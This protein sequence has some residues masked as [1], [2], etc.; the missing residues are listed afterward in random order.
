MYCSRISMRVISPGTSLSGTGARL[1]TMQPARETPS[2][3]STSGDG[4]SLAG[5]IVSNRA[6]VPLK[7]VPGDITLMLILEQYIPFRQGTPQ[8]APYALTAILDNDLARRA[9]E[10]VGAG[11]DWVGQDVEHSIVD[12]QF[13][14]NAAP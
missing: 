5:C 8:S 14:N 1:L 11:I 7:L 6:P 4:V 3:C 2:P 12:W 9:A 13:P 10:G